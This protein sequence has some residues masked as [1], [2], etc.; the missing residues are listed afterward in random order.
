MAGGK[1]VVLGPA[2]LPANVFPCLNMV[3]TLA[4]I[5]IVPFCLCE[6]GGLF[7]AADV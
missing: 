2:I 5:F 4:L 3:F 7:Q 1:A 6:V